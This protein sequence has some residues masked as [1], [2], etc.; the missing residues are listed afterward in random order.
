MVPRVFSRSAAIAI[1]IA[2][3]VVVSGSAR[4]DGTQQASPT[5]VLEATNPLGTILT[6]SSGMTLYILSSEV[7]GTIKCSGGCL[8]IW[9]PLTVPSGTTPT[10]PADLPGKLG[11][12][13]RPDGTLQVTYQGFPLYHFVRD[14]KPGD[15]RGNFIIAFE[16]E[17]FAAQPHA[18]PLSATPV[19]SGTIRIGASA[20]KPLG[21]VQVWYRLG[22]HIASTTCSAASCTLF[23][24]LGL[25]VH[26]TQRP[27]P[28]SHFAGWLVRSP[29]RSPLKSNK[30]AVS[31]RMVAG[32]RAHARYRN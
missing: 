4:A 15:T 17:W 21:L 22:G 1:C 30:S 10:G 12:I 23:A 31:F 27:T 32:V 7:G 19:A 14:Q 6:D 28:G 8:S 16:G 18:A 29:G 20:G 26:L 25:T 2:A 13:T 11:T 3:T 24:P 9:P 5:T